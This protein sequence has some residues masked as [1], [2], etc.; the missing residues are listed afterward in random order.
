MSTLT[1]TT[2]ML[3]R[4]GS[5]VAGGR[6]CDEGDPDRDPD[7]NL[8]SLRDRELHKCHE[9]IGSAGLMDPNLGEK[10]PVGAGYLTTGE[11]ATVLRVVHFVTSLM[12]TK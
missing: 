9:L 2:G 11:L 7:R 4:R 12:I 3:T 5:C 10:M 8:V 1:S 6:V